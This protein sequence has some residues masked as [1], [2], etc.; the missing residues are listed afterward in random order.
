MEK[1]TDHCD[2]LAMLF[3]ERDAVKD[4]IDQKIKE[5]KKK[6]S[7]LNEFHAK[8]DEYFAY[9]R[10]VKA[11]KKLQY[12]QDKKRHKRQKFNMKRSGNIMSH[13]E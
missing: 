1:D 2:K 13:T 9:T 3:L 8:N 10:V 5:K 6:K 11:Q 4:E 12:D 7:I